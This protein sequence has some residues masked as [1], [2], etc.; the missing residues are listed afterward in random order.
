MFGRPNYALHARTVSTFPAQVERHRHSRLKYV[1][2]CRK[3]IVNLIKRSTF[4]RA[5][6][7]VDQIRA[8]VSLGFTYKSFRL[9]IFHQFKTIKHRVLLSSVKHK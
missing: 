3:L 2:K 9:K 8:F 5:S 1:I 6:E 4:V 7:R